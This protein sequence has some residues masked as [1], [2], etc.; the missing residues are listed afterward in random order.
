M[1]KAQ[2]VREDLDKICRSSDAVWLDYDSIH[3]NDGQA[4]LDKYLKAYEYLGVDKGQLMSLG[5]IVLKF[6]GGHQISYGSAAALG[7]Y[8]S[9]NTK[10]GKSLVCVS[11]FDLLI[12]QYSVYHECGHLFQNKLN[13]FNDSALRRDYGRYL[14]E[15]H[16]NIFASAVIFLKTPKIIDY[17]K[18]QVWMFSK[19]VRDFFSSDDAWQGSFGNKVSRYYYVSLPIELAL[20]RDIHKQG[21][22]NF[23][24]KYTLSNGSIDFENLARYCKQIVDN[25]AY[26]QDYFMGIIKNPDT[27]KEQRIYK[28]KKV[29]RFLGSAFGYHLAAQMYKKT[30]QH[31]AIDRKQRQLQRKLLKPLPDVDDEAIIFNRVADI[32]MLQVAVSQKYCEPINLYKVVSKDKEVYDKLKSYKSRSPE[33]YKAMRAAYSKICRIYNENQDSEQFKR[34]FN[35]ISEPFKGRAAFWQL[36]ET[37]RMQLLK[38][39]SEKSLTGQVPKINE[40]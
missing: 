30:K 10:N 15:V 20:L 36:H 31:Q 16:A 12:E 34:Q 19:G 3:T 9:T 8:I 18:A 17:K 22:K 24:K 13:F 37:K 2:E 32:D 7:G 33:K 1:L 29:Y 28:Q 35:Q 39:K 25:N 38:Q 11:G 14:S 21:R 6:G 4:D 5:G 26:S 40:R 23:I 27:F